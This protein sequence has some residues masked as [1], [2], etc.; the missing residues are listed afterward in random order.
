MVFSVQDGSSYWMPPEARSEVIAYSLNVDTGLKGSPQP[1]NKSGNTKQ[2]DV[3]TKQTSVRVVS[4]LNGAIKPESTIYLKSNQ[5]DTALKV[6]KVTHKGSYEG[7]D[8]DTIIE[9]D[10]VDAV[11]NPTVVFGGNR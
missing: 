9:G 1:I 8:W 2:G 11:V 5:Y 4:T 6:T 3:K 7:N 10:I